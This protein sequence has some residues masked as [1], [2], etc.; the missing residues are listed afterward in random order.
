MQQ[1]AEEFLK[2]SSATVGSGEI[3]AKTK[4]QNF[5][6]KITLKVVDNQLNNPKIQI[7]YM[8]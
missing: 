6:G 4:F 3:R 2:K 1:S 5:Q 8:N 7:I